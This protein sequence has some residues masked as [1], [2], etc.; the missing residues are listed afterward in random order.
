MLFELIFVFFKTSLK[1]LTCPITFRMKQIL[2]KCQKS[3][4]FELCPGNFA[5]GIRDQTI[6]EKKGT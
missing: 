1:I 2:P 3:K 4:L 6:K 5:Y